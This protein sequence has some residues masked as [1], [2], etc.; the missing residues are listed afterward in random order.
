M[1][2]IIQKYQPEDAKF[3]CDKHPDR[4]CFSQLE[5]TSWYGSIFDMDNIK[6]HL[7]DVCVKEMYDHLKKEFNVEPTEL[8]L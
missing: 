8:S 1:K 4:E 5:L 3:F 7:C 2:H 6:V